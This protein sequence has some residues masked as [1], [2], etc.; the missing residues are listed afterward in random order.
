MEFPE[1][2]EESEPAAP[3]KI[4]HY[5]ELRHCFL[6]LGIVLLERGKWVD[7]YRLAKRGPI[8]PSYIDFFTAMPESALKALSL[9]LLDGRLTQF[10]LFKAFTTGSPPPDILIPVK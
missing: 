2:K 4:L 1:T 8:H 6:D 3:V 5:N 9:A 7:F 10:A